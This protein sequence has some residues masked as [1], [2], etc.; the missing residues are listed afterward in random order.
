MSEC[1]PKKKKAEKD[2]A[3]E[4]PD[5]VDALEKCLM[6]VM[7]SQNDTLLKH[8]TEIEN[9]MNER[10]EIIKTEMNK[11]YDKIQGVEQKTIDIEMKLRQG[12]RFL[13]D[14]VML[15]ECKLL[16]G[17]VRFR[18]VPENDKEVREEMVNIIAE[19]LEMSPNEVER[20][21]DVIYR[22][23]SNFAK[24][25]KLPRDIVVNLITHKMCDLILAKQYQ[26]PM[27]IMGKQIKIWK[28]LLRELIKQRKEYRQLTDKLRQEQVRYRWEIPRGVSFM[29]NQKRYLR[30]TAE[31]MNEFLTNTTG[32]HQ[33]NQTSQK[34]QNGS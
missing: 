32:E 12:N 22:V 4:K 24:Q 8:M 2:E 13:K 10:I 19:F 29:F 9:K 21:C 18:G 15:L 7:E 14:Q 11:S 1:L 26:E 34:D 25:K 28:E 16:D 23:N 27:E 3:K 6:S 5:W 30:K 17:Y 31:Q 33:R 20:K